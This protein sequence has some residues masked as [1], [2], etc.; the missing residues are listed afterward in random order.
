MNPLTEIRLIL[1]RELR[2]QFRSTKGLVLVILSVLVATL[3]SL[4]LAYGEKKQREMMPVELTPEQRQAVLAEFLEKTGKD[5]ATAKYL[6]SIPQTV[7]SMWKVAT[8]TT[9]WLVLLLGYDSLASDVQYRTIRFW[10]VRTRR[11]SYFLGKWLGLFTTVA[12]LHLAISSIVWVVSAVMGTDNI[13]SILR[14]GVQLW[15]LSLPITAAWTGLASGIGSFF[16]TP[17]VALLTIFGTYIVVGIVAIIGAVRDIE[18]LTFFWPNSL[19]DKFLLAD[20]KHVGVGLLACAL[21]AALPLVT[22]AFALSKRDV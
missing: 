18:F 17:M 2:R 22:G 21:Y 8:F 12:A 13:G 11:S 20:T 6:A 15:I 4:A 5:A 3:I 7:L 1:F 10:T 16:R 14:W 19:D 9:P